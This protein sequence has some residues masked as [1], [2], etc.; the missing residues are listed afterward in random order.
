MPRRKEWICECEWNCACGNCKNDE[1]E[2]ECHCID[3]LSNEELMSI[4]IKK[5][6]L[7]MSDVC[8]KTRN[9]LMQLIVEKTDDPELIL[10]EGVDQI[11]KN[12]K[13]ASNKSVYDERLAE[14]FDLADR[15]DTEKL[16]ALLQQSSVRSKQKNK[17]KRKLPKKSTFFKKTKSRKT[18]R[19]AKADNCDS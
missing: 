19:R 3:D 18:S 4:M 2:C 16:Q 13:K 12:L 15:G 5:G 10:K 14:L 1:C 11:H 7:I 9:Q 17:G 8:G 6:N